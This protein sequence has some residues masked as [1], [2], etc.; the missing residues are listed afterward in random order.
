MFDALQFRE[1]WAVD[2][3]FQANS[4]D[5]PIPICLVAKELRSGRIVRQWENEFGDQPPYSTGHD[6]L[7]IAYY[8]SAELGCHRALGWQDPVHILDLCAEFKDHTSGLA[9]PAGRGLLGA[10]VYHGLDHIGADEK[11]EMRDLAM[12]GGPWA[13]RE[14]IDLLDYCQTDVDALER[15]LPAMLPYLD[16]PHALLRGAYMAAAAAMEWAGVPIDVLTLERLQKHWEDI[17]SRL[18]RSTPIARDLYDGN[19]FKRDR[20]VAFLVAHDIRWPLLETGQPDLEDETFAEM[21]DIHP[22]IRPI[23]DVR[24]GMAGLRLSS[25][26]VGKDGRNRT[27]LGAFN[28]KTGRNQPSNSKFIFGP[29]KWMRGLIKPE[30]GYALACLD[31]EQ[32]EFGIAAALSGDPAMIEAYQSGDPYLAFAKQAGAV[33]QDATK[34]SHKAIRE[35]YKACVL[36]VQ[37]GMGYRSLALRIGQFPIIARKLLKAHHDAFPVFWDWSDRVF[38]HG[39]LMGS[40]H[41]VFNWHV[42]VDETTKSRS[43]LNFPMQGNGAEMLRLACCFATKAGIEICAPIHDAVLIR[44]PTDRLDIKIDRM[45]E[46]M[47]EASSIVLSGFELRVE[48]KPEIKD[49]QG[50]TI[51]HG[52]YW[53]NRFM[54]ERG[55]E[56]WGRIMCLLDGVEAQKTAEAAE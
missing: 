16:L 28:S 17:K 10:L 46:C 36:A 22:V 50:K 37:Y 21:S 26:T 56:M 40:V 5:R 34:E 14:R 35:Q 43:L 29:A 45:R 12:R 13:E 15:L 19:T 31:W 47:R 1:V 27:L 32:Q 23:Y 9:V 25:L 2:Y 52:V 51:G 42:H 20:F 24:H 49:A 48:V 3:E 7:F 8:A 53:P 30:P 44:A 4:G 11:K 38:N 33:P 18:I 55:V 39:C 6:S 54:D 41:T